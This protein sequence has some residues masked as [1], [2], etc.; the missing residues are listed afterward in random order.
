[1]LRD[2][3]LSPGSKFARPS[4]ETGHARSPLARTAVVVAIVIA[5]VTIIF[6]AGDGVRKLAF[7]GS[8]HGDPERHDRRGDRVRAA[9]PFVGL[10]LWAFLQ[11]AAAWAGARDAWCREARLPDRGRG[12]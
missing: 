5:G 4:I 7:V 9:Q 12:R 8:W 11:T 2:H 3:T 6:S 10:P 1:M